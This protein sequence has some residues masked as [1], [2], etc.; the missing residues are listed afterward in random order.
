MDDVR[1]EP[2][3]GSMSFTGERI[4][5]C[6]L[7]KRRKLSRRRRL[8]GGIGGASLIFAKCATN[9]KPFPTHIEDLRKM[10]IKTLVVLGLMMGG[11]FAFQKSVV[12]VMERPLLAIDPDRTRLT[13]FGVA[14]PLTIAIELSFYAGLV[15]GVSFPCAFSGRVC[16]A[17]ADSKGKAHAATLQRRCRLAFSWQVSC[18]LIIV[19]CRPR[20]IIFSTIQ[21]RSIGGRS[22]ASGNISHSPRNLSYPSASPLSCRWRCCCS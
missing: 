19:C 13:N 3:I 1:V 18:S 8:I 11:A 16:L 17:G 20:L 9:L 10:L 4:P 21:S 14:D 5:E 22:G 7:R 6:K 2:V 15:M 12:E